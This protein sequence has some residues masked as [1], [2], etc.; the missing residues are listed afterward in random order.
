M[1]NKLGLYATYCKATGAFLRTII[2]R[3][4]QIY[5]SNKQSST[6]IHELLTEDEYK[7]YNYPEDKIPKQSSTWSS[8]DFK[9]MSDNYHLCDLCNEYYE[10]EDMDYIPTAEELHESPGLCAQC[11][12]CAE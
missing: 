9:S 3:R 7:T 6:V 11:V 1:K 5:M 10:I 4:T 8:D 2:K 12:N